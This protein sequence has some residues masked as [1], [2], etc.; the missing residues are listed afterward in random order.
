MMTQI[1]RKN[2][3]LQGLQGYKPLQLNN[4]NNLEKSASKKPGLQKGYRS[5]KQPC[6]VTFVTSCNQ[7][8]VTNTNEQ[9]PMLSRLKI[10]C[11]LVTRVTPKKTQIS[12]SKP[13]QEKHI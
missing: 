12:N 13:K 7:H 2:F 1:M 5:Y 8:W 11:N 6:V 3:G 4:I 9:K 10:I